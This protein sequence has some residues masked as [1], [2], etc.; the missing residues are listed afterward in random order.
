MTGRECHYSYVSPHGEIPIPTHVVLTRYPITTWTHL[1]HQWATYPHQQSY[2]GLAVC[3]PGINHG[4]HQ[5]QFWVILLVLVALGHGI[6][7]TILLTDLSKVTV[8]ASLFDF[9]NHTLDSVLFFRRPTAPKWGERVPTNGTNMSC[10]R[11][12]F[13]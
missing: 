12:Q 9:F 3:G 11:L 6:M 4:R 5:S 13:N 8:N 7:T 10:N 1:S 2:H